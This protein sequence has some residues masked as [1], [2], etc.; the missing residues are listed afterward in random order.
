MEF[1]TFELKLN[2]NLF[3]VLSKIQFEQI[4][5]HRSAA[6]LVKVEN[7]RI[8]IVRTTTPYQNKT[9]S[10]DL[11]PKELLNQ[12][13]FET[14]NALVELYKP[15]HKNMKFQSYQALDLED[16]SMIQIYSC[17]QEPCEPNK[18]LTVFNKR[19][20]RSEFIDFEHN[21]LVTFSTETNKKYSHQI[22]KS[23]ETNKKWITITFRKSKTFIGVNG[24]FISLA[25]ENE[26]KQMCK[27]KKE[28]NDS[29]DFQWPKLSYTVSP[30]DLVL[31]NL[32]HL[33]NKR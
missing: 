20:K 30:S 32:H 23:S 11:I 9:Q 10:F 27:Y 6:L 18:L 21:S 15:T 19:T 12:L 28:E 24:E 14:N 16:N 5:P 1:K 29:A 26:K 3:K 8:P 7:N 17:Y 31:N 25:G 33:I 4:S 22:S 2:D 13:P